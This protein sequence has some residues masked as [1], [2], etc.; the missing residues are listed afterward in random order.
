MK[1]PN[2]KVTL[3]SPSS[4]GAVNTKAVITVPILLYRSSVG[5]WSQASGLAFFILAVDYLLK[6]V[7]LSLA[8]APATCSVFLLWS[9][10][11][12]QLVLLFSAPLLVHLAE[13]VQ[14]V[15]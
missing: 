12:V 14:V 1:V 5:L 11:P 7:T 3:D 4:I 2:V 13:V 8:H 10:L 9:L 15:I 6:G